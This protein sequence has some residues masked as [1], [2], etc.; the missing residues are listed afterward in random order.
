MYFDDCVHIEETDQCFTCTHFVRG[1]TCPLLEALATGVVILQDDVG[2]QN[3]GFYQKH[4]R[5]LTVM[6]NDALG[7]SSADS[8]AEPPSSTASATIHYLRP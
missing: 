1:V 4:V 6:G 8:L 2:V 3:C 7:S 5:H